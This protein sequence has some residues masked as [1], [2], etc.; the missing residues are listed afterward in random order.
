MIEDRSPLLPTKEERRPRR[1][2][3]A[4]RWSS[5]VIS[6]ERLIRP[7]V[8]IATP[9]RRATTDNLS[10]IGSESESQFFSNTYLR[11]SVHE[12]SLDSAR[13]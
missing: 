13:L 5:G 9:S 10:S 8:C 2:S 4:G 11:Y 7:A 1:V 12:T 6:E 3:K